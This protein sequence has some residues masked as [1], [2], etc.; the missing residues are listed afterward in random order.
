MLTFLLVASVTACG[1]VRLPESVTPRT[2]DP[3][4]AI[5]VRFPA[6]PDVPNAAA[7]R[8]DAFLLSGKRTVAIGRTNADVGQPPFRYSDDGGATWQEG[9]LTAA[10]HN[11]TKVGENATGLGAVKPGGKP[12]WLQLGVLDDAFV[13][14]T[15]ADGAT[16]SRADT[17]G[18]R[19]KAVQFSAMT[20]TASG[21]L[22]VG[23]RFPADA[24][25]VPTAWRS[26][27]GV[28]WTETPMGTRGLP[29]A[30]TYAHDRLVAVGTETFEE[31]DPQGR[32][33]VGLAY[34]STDAGATWRTHDLPQPKGTTP[35][36]SEAKA[37][38]ATA[39]GFAGGGS[40]YSHD[41]E[42]YRPSFFTSQDG[43]SWRS[44]DAP[45]RG[46][47]IDALAA[48]GALVLASIRS[49][50][51]GVS[52]TALARFD[53]AG[54]I[55]V[56]S[57]A[58]KGA[59]FRTTGLSGGAGG[60]LVSYLDQSGL[61]DAGGAWRSTDGLA[62][63]QIVLGAG[64][65]SAAL[66]PTA[67]AVGPDQ[68]RRAVGMSQ[69]R[70]LI[71]QVDASGAGSLP[72]TLVEGRPYTITQASAGAPGTMV[73]GSELVSGRPQVAM[74]LLGS[75]SKV[76]RTGNP[77]RVPG[78]SASTEVRDVQW[79]G[80]RWVAVGTETSNGS[81]R[82]SAMVYTSTD[83]V[84]WD[85]GRA[86]KTYAT[87][88]AYGANDRLTDLAGLD[89]RQ[90]GMTAVAAAGTGLVAVGWVTE[91]QAEYGAF[92]RSPDRATWTLGR[93]PAPE[94][95]VTWVAQ[96]LA[97]SG[98]VLVASGWSL[99]KDSD[100]ERYHLWTSTDAGA[101][102][103]V[104][105]TGDAARDDGY[106]PITLGGAIVAL[107]ERKDGSALTALVSTDGLAWNAK[108]VAIPD[109]RAGMRVALTSVA[110]EGDHLLLLV[111]LTGPTA[112]RTVVV[113]YAPPR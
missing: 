106:R 110:V 18:L 74:W 31:R 23:A 89:G 14:W 39:A 68:V 6:D 49:R 86:A 101:T 104:T 42:D 8:T 69:G 64:T 30:V 10:A 40:V 4:T 81:A 37:V 100:Q 109:Y 70:A 58:T 55:N 84:R 73:W 47:S 48:S 54:W 85:K 29:V 90:R 21:F 94:G 19:L 2:P 26:A 1:L 72:A 43:E 97:S 105:L 76:T 61:A 82:M 46:V 108:P 65:T 35:F 24:A 41:A 88:D 38:I 63:E 27:D 113:P 80:D 7:I 75:G 66:Q 91:G 52:E 67:L 60:F 16:W 25:S 13:A 44:V 20:A 87:G 17:V 78:G 95:A 15:S 93:L 53:G 79:V 77:M 28:T 92:W 12:V 56:P 5:P 98:S 83:G 9:A 107:Q 57:P 62:Y 32:V 96:R 112:K 36:C 103:K 50:T 59:S 11:A 33:C 51:A 102:W 111:A 99:A 45:D 3:V 71:W 22:L 34:T